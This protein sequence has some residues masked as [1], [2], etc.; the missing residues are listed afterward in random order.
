MTFIILEN[1]VHLH[2]RQTISDGIIP[3]VEGLGVGRKKGKGKQEKENSVP[4]EKQLAR[5]ETRSYPGA[6]HA[7]KLRVPCDSAYGFSC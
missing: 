2:E 1:G 3:E 6:E 4:E 5:N 7:P